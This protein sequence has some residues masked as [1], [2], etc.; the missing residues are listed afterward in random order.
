MLN[1]INKNYKLILILIVLITLLLKILPFEVRSW[2]MD[3]DSQIVKEALQI[4][5]SV[6]SG[7]WEFLKEP[8]L[9]PFI[10][11][12]IYLFFYGLFFLIGKLI[13]LFSSST[14]FVDYIYF[15]IQSLY[16]WSRILIAVFGTLLIPLVFSITRRIIQKID[17]QKAIVLSLFAS[18]LVA[19]NLI[20]NIFSQQPRPH[21]LVAFFILLTFYFYLRFL[22]YKK[23][24]DYFLLSL[25]CGLAIGVLQNGIFAVIFF[26]LASYYLFKDTYLKTNKVFA[27]FSWLKFLLAGLIILIIFVISYPYAILNFSSVLEAQGKFESVNGFDFTLSSGSQTFSGI[28]GKGINILIRGLLFY[29]QVLS[30]I[31]LLTFLLYI[32][33][34]FRKKQLYNKIKNV[35]FD[36]SLVGLYLF[37]ILYILILIIYDGARIRFMSPLTPFLCVIGAVFLLKYIMQAKTSVKRVILGLIM[38]LMLFEFVQVLRF[39]HILSQPYTRDESVEWIQKN[40]PKDELI[41]IQSRGPILIPNRKSLE[42][43]E[44]INPESL[45]TKDNFLLELP[46]D[47]YP[48]DNNYILRLGLVGSEFQTEEELES[49]LLELKPDYFVLFYTTPKPED[50]IDDFKEFRLAEKYGESIKKFTP[51]KNE[52]KKQRMMFTWAFENPIVDLWNFKQLG[53]II[54]VYELKW[55]N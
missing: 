39:V 45:T 43:Q 47:K 51:F 50:F 30:F 14:E 11:P 27:N 6:T 10:G 36:R 20:L 2:T 15:H 4:G 52:D 8:V 5:E 16:W 35:V 28:N 53:P 46:L 44:S 48:A 34:K 49:L 3:A 18:S 13:G 24:I 29:H 54:D 42:L 31:F 19:L 23:I 21:V 12:Y 1:W 33:S 9:F 38:V 17:Q 26:V 41:L 7:D 55:D 22:D 37:T 25:S 32:F 40:I